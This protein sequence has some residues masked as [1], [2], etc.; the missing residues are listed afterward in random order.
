MRTRGNDTARPGAIRPGARRRWLRPFTLSLALA[1]TLGGAP[2]AAPGAAASASAPAAPAVPALP[3][4]APE[5]CPDCQVYVVNVPLEPT[6]ESWGSFPNTTVSVEV[7]LPTD[8]S[9]VECGDEYGVVA[10]DGSTEDGLAVAGWTCKEK[11]G[12]LRFSGPRVTDSAGAAVRFLFQA[13]SPGPT[14]PA[15]PLAAGFIDVLQTYLDG[16]QQLRRGAKQMLATRPQAQSTLPATVWLPPKWIVADCSVPYNAVG[17]PLT[18]WNCALDLLAGEKYRARWTP[19]VNNPPQ[20]RLFYFHAFTKKN[21]PE[22]DPVS[23]GNVDKLIDVMF[24]D[25]QIP[26]VRLAHVRPGFRKTPSTVSP[27]PRPSSAGKSKRDKKPYDEDYDFEDCQQAGL[28]TVASPSVNRVDFPFGPP[29]GYPG[30]GWYGNYGDPCAPPRVVIDPCAGKYFS[31][32][33]HGRFTPR[34]RPVASACLPPE[35][36]EPQYAG[37]AAPPPAPTCIPR[38]GRDDAERAD[39]SYRRPALRPAADPTDPPVV[40]I[41]PGDADTVA[42]LR[43]A[44]DRVLATRATPSPEPTLAALLPEAPV[45]DPAALPYCEEEDLP[46]TG[47]NSV[48]LLKLALGALA[49]GSA[50]VAGAV[51]WRRHT[52]RERWYSSF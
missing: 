50:L 9:S 32:F 36:R 22:P 38:P 20:A 24:E 47:G 43:G 16:E 19:V 15:T 41:P 37:I 1:W 17:D 25:G 51:Y 29:P 48:P 5:V 21:D 28:L 8:W 40:M 44:E 18:G 39:R 45:A 46:K 27:T 42:R 30:F 12:T 31:E 33:G 35:E 14:D 49:I 11:K 34:R 13:E 10:R 2:A 23:L 52:Y 7:D 4:P 6:K 26:T 3:N